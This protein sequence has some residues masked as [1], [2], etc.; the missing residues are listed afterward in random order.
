MLLII[1]ILIV[2]RRD[3]ELVGRKAFP[4]QEK[5]KLNYEISIIELT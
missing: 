3:Y 4:K 5:V 1:S 2:K